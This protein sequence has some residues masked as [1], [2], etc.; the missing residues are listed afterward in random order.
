MRAFRTQRF[1]PT[2]CSIWERMGFAGMKVNGLAW[3]HL[4]IITA[5]LPGSPLVYSRARKQLEPC[6]ASTCTD[7]VVRPDG[8][9]MFVNR[10]MR[11]TVA[12]VTFNPR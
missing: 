2:N 12:G 7:R 11:M 1:V 6:S 9:E 5:L 8:S 10:A 3:H 4:Q